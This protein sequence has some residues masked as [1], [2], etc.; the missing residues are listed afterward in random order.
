V[1]RSK[2]E[3]KPERIAR[4]VAEAVHAGKEWQLPGVDFNDLNRPKTC[5]EVDFPILPIN[6]VAAIEGNAG[7]PIYQMS[8]WWARRRSSV[9]R[10]MLIAAATKAPDDHAEADKLVWDAYYGN[11]QKNEAFRKL[12]VADIFMGGGTTI[13]E[14]ARLG[15]QMYGNDL[16]PVAWFVVKNELAQVDPQEVKKLLAHIQAEVKPQIMPFYA[17]DCPRGHKGKWTHKPTKKVMPQTFDPLAL[18]PQQ[19]PEYEYEG[20][21]V[22]YTFWSKH[23][24]CQN[25]ECGHRTP[26]M[27]SPVVA[28]KSLSVGVWRNKNCS[29]CDKTFDVEA[30]E[31]RMA[32]AASFACSPEEP[33]YAIRNDDGTFDCPHCGHINK[34][35]IGN[36]DK[37]D[38]KINLT[39]LIHPDWLKGAPS[40]DAKG[41]PFGGSV[42]DD[43]EST[44][45]WNAERTKTLK[46]IEVRGPL[47]DE[48]ECPDT[49]EKFRT[50]G[51]TVPKKS[52]FI[53]MEATC[54]KQWDVLESIK[55]TKNSGPV[56]MYAVQGYCP[57]CDKAGK[58]Y[59]GRFFGTPQVRGYDI[60][61]QEWLHRR[62]ADLAKYWPRSE[63][64]FGFMTSMNNGGIPNHGFTHWWT[65]FNPRQLLVHTL[66]LQGMVNSEKWSWDSRELVLGAFQQYLRN[67]NLFCIWNTTADKMEP[68]FSNNN[69]HPKAT[70]VENCVFPQL[71]RGNWQSSSSG[72]LEGLA[73][74][75]DPWETVSVFELEKVAREVV[76]EIP[77]LSTKVHPGDLVRNGQHIDCLTS[78][79]LR[80]LTD[81]SYDLVITDPPFGGLLHY[82]ELAD[83]FYVWLRLVLKE[84]YPDKFTAEYTPKAL[85]AVANRARHPDD[86]DSFYQ[87]ILTE[88]WREAG[89]ILKPSGILAFTFHHSEDE[90]WV[91]VLESLFQAG[92]YLEA[93]YPIRS[94]E[95]K[96]E[97]AKPGTF[98]SQLIE[99]DIIHVCRKRIEEPNEVS[100]ARL[101]RQIMQ[102]VR[103]LQDILTK[104]QTAGLQE[105]DMQVIR[106]GKALEYYSKHY[107]KVYV[108]KG[109]E[110][111]VR[112][113]LLAINQLLDDQT[114]TS[115]EA[116]PVL[117]ESYTRQF[118]RLFAD[119]TSIPRDQ[120]SKH[121]RGTGVSPQA[122][123]E[124]GWCSEKAKVFTPVSPLDW[125][126]SKK[127]TRRDGMSRDF[128]QVMFMVGACCEGSG[129]KLS[130][131]LDNPNFLPHP[132][133]EPG[134][135]LRTPRAWPEHYGVPLVASRRA[136]RRV[137]ATR[138][139]R[140]QTI[141]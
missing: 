20:P 122:F 14:G 110:F 55:K 75:A 31:A 77:G 5:L 127:G 135:P 48:I 63:V 51:G 95:T 128:D 120:M 130:E 118:L 126:L 87:K 132:A 100:W 18:T 34:S 21:E 52:T 129:I 137:S 39:L 54:G 79:N 17:C 113:A 43:A 111:T 29:A 23:G 10:A 53:C 117:A 36:S 3:T 88:C 136:Q 91:A 61:Y 7:K 133:T 106:R 59:S 22:I 84:K 37:K 32:P 83:F 38:K 125:A 74:C 64:P 42:S 25:T 19:R 134:R 68:M 9:F 16:N 116:P 96:G 109:R 49:K 81:S 45:R 73:W 27:S 78:S 44:A 90:P 141:R 57:A 86:A 112:E 47:P 15:M 89:R 56:A 11:H 105:A 114:D 1:A 123:I 93:A 67:Q 26:I 85:E 108:E 8:K 24:P 6:H 72:I 94:D 58:P 115:S 92:F 76:D 4:I 2:T 140:N 46:L 35:A 30:Q 62:E 124:R 13:V 104:H 121:M 60:A 131:T 28:V 97:G 107:G 33:P 102:D 101:R 65:M 41:R 71:G 82:S 69:Y 103:Q 98:G 139:R 80:H 40:K 99:Y 138:V 50:D 70:M 119:K 66:L 12:K